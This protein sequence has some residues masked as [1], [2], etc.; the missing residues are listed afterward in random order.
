MGLKNWCLPPFST[1]GNKVNGQPHVFPVNNSF[2]PPLAHV[3]IFPF[4]HLTSCLICLGMELPLFWKGVT[5]GQRLKKERKVPRAE[6]KWSLEETM[7]MRLEQQPK[8]QP[9]KLLGFKV[10]E[11]SLTPISLCCLSAVHSPNKDSSSPV[12]CA[13][14]SPRCQDTAVIKKDKAS[15]SKNL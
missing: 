5:C 7:N 10:H 11:P 3:G 2:C 15:D 1:S 9:G 13:R 12:Q 8:G 4:C 14:Q 6:Q